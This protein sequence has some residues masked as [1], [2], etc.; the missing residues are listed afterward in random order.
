MLG[1]AFAFTSEWSPDKGSGALRH[2]RSALAVCAIFSSC[3]QPGAAGAI[4]EIR[5]GVL[6]QG[7]GP[8]SPDKEEGAGINAEIL[9]RPLAALSAIGAPRPH[10]GF[11]AATD[12][13]AT[14]QIYGGLTWELSL[15]AKFFADAG[16][17]LAVHDGETDFDPM[18]PNIGST[19]FLGCRALFRL[20]GD[21]GYRL[22]ERLSVSLHADHISNAGLCSENEGLDNTGLRLGYRF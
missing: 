7:A 16:L 21:L 4:D 13:D 20:S 3:P 14:S 12:G 9:F 5:G 19:Q 18:D 8:I 17:G 22:T 6:L 10:L 15:T 1:G 11:S 2:L